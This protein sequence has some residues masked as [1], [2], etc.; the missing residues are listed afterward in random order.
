MH[1]DVCSS[2]RSI[3]VYRLMIQVFISFDIKWLNY[4]RR[5]QITTMVTITT[6]A[7]TVE[8]ATDKAIVNIFLLSE[9][10]RALVPTPTT[11]KPLACFNM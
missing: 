2:L 7:T 8:M 1:C 3:G 10:E 4:L 11:I 6:T 5:L 9:P